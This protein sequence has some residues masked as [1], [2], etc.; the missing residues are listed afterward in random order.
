[1]AFPAISFAVLATSGAAIRHGPHHAAQKSASTG[2][3]AS[4][5]ISSNCCTSTFNGSSTGGSADLHFPQ[6]PVSARWRAGTRFLV[7]QTLQNKVGI[8]MLLAA[9]S[10]FLANYVLLIDA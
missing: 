3:F 10:Q 6:R 1:M 8:L 4:F 2:T 5:T 7:P 9:S